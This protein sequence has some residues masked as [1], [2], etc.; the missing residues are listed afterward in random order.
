MANSKLTTPRLLKSMRHG[1]VGR[2][3]RRKPPPRRSPQRKKLSERGRKMKGKWKWIGIFTAFFEFVKLIAGLV[4]TKKNP[5]KIE[6]K[7][8]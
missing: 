2:L 1:K 4:K 6:P 7:K 8:K 5:D 3:L